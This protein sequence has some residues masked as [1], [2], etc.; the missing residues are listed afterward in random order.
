MTSKKAVLSQIEYLLTLKTIT[1]TYEE[2]AASR[3]QRIRASVFK[4]RDFVLEI[5]SIFQEVKSSYKKELEAL[6][7]RKKIKD[8][9]K[10][11]F[12][13]HNGKTLFVLLSSNTGLYG[14]I[15]GRTFSLFTKYLKQEK[16]DA[17]IIGRFGYQEFKEEFP[18][19]KATYFY[20]PENKDTESQKKIISFL[21]QYEKIVV[22]YGR[23]RNV[24]T[25][26]PL[27]LNISGD[28][29]PSDER[30]A[31]T[32]YFFEPSL[33]KVLELF[34]KEIFA[35]I[36]EQ[37]VLEAS[38]AQFAARMVALDQATANTRK[39][40]KS[41]MLQ[42]ERIRHQIINKKQLE[43]LSSISLWQGR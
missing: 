3:M 18:K 4:S 21:I 2:I 43:T 20:L 35:S 40:L 17:A 1:E 14:D 41:T 25:Q 22:F 29:L 15:I 10:F 19:M 42:Q 8:P 38:L 23:F 30:G 37:I 33:E 13:N 12:I 26:E 24:V 5:N 39:L 34:E 7:K 16:A 11:S 36:F 6:M 9:L 32:K 27:M 31:Q 28:L